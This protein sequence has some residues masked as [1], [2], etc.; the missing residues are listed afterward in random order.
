MRMPDRTVEYQDEQGRL[1]VIR[2]PA[3][4]VQ[5]QDAL[6]QRHHQFI[7]THW[8]EL[9]AASLSGYRQAGEG[10]LIISEAS[11]PSSKALQTSFAIH[12]LAYATPEALSILQEGL[13]V[14]HWLSD[15][16]EQY[17]PQHTILLLFATAGE[18]RAYAVDGDPPPPQALRFVQAI[19]N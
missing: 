14:L 6:E 4:L 10:V 12:R 5:M 3:D 17:D 7:I 19:N 1:F 2:A 9:A 18:P 16:L 11:P 8:E 13:Q 15:Q